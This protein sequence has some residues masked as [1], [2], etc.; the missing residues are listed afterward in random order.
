MSQALDIVHLTRAELCL[1]E[2]LHLLDR[3][4]V[5]VRDPALNRHRVQIEE[6]VFPA[7]HARKELQKDLNALLKGEQSH[8]LD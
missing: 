1:T 4:L 2:A 7:L 3:A 8:A 5:I 6:L